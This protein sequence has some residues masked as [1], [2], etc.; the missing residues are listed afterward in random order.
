MV[1]SV[2]L[3]LL[4][5]ALAAREASAEHPIAGVISLLEKLEVEAKTEGEAEAATYQ[6]FTYWCKRSTKMLTRAMKKEKKAIEQLT[7]KMTARTSTI[8]SALPT[9]PSQ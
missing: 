8:R 2:V 1:R 7:D 3:L 4:L 5:G 6:K 9:R